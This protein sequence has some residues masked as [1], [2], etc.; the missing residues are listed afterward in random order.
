M[1]T[2]LAACAALIGFGGIV[3]IGACSNDNAGTNNVD[4]SADAS[5]DGGSPGDAQVVVEADTGVAD[6][7]GQ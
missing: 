3:A 1:R 4:A 2:R 7:P 5:P 6:A